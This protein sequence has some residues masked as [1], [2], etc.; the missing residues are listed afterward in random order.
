[1]AITIFGIVAASVFKV[2]GQTYLILQQTRD[3][4]LVSQTMQLQM[5]SLR[6]MRWDDFE[7]KVGKE[8]FDVDTNGI[9]ASRKGTIPFGWQAYAFEQNIQKD[10]HKKG[11]YKCSLTINWTDTRGKKNARTF[12][13]WFTEK[14]L[15]DYYVKPSI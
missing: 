7:Q 9:I 15:N 13:S 10:V 5:E 6:G 8:K 14:G 4:S 12:I 11:L 1:M 2:Y 3:M